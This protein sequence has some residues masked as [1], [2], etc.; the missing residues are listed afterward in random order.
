LGPVGC[1]SRHN[2]TAQREQNSKGTAATRAIDGT[3]QKNAF[4]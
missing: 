2:T 1:D 3:F 4:L